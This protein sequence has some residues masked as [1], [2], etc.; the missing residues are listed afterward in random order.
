[1]RERARWGVARERTFTW[2]EDRDNRDNNNAG[3]VRKLGRGIRF[4][5]GARRQPFSRGRLS[6]ARPPIS[7]L[8]TNVPDS[9]RASLV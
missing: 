1:V 9:A 3:S 7:C 5:L 2:L 4:G 6:T 8:A